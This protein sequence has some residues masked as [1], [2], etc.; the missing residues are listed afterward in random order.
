MLLFR[1]HER[2]EE[3]KWVGI[4]SKFFDET[5]KRVDPRHLEEKLG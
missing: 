3:K 4:A 5:G 2:Y 1:L